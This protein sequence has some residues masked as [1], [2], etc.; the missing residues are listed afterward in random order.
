VLMT[1]RKKKTVDIVT[2]LA[3]ILFYPRRITRENSVKVT[4]GLF[5]IAYLCVR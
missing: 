3:Q 1:K 4:R 2:T 5:S